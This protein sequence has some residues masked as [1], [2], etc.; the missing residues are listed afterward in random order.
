MD[1]IAFLLH[2]LLTLMQK[3]LLRTHPK[4]LLTIWQNLLVFLEIKTPSDDPKTLLLPLISSACDFQTKNMMNAWE[5]VGER[6]R[7]EGYYA[8]S[9]SVKEMRSDGIQAWSHLGGILL[10]AVLILCN[11][12]MSAT[13]RE[14]K[15][16]KVWLYVKTL[17]MCRD[18]RKHTGQSEP[19]AK[20]A[21]PFKRD[22]NR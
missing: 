6:L 22:W 8:I 9:A 15:R 14:N 1:T 7:E 19:S 11:G 20:S 2:T 17:Y 10:T 16:S 13:W 18:F 12:L 3:R 4:N 5:N 21:L